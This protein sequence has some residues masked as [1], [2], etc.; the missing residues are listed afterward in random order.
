METPHLFQV[1]QHAVVD[2]VL[3]EINAHGVDHFLD[4]GVVDGSDCRVR[5]GDCWTAATEAANR[6]LDACPQSPQTIASLTPLHPAPRRLAQPLITSFLYLIFYARAGQLNDRFG[7]RRRS[8][9]RSVGWMPRG[10]RAPQAFSPALALRSVFFGISRSL[11]TCQTLA[12][13]YF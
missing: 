1:L 13:L 10:M 3:L 4:D 11:K 6:L 2:A 8:G 5:H 9:G 7:L 12:I